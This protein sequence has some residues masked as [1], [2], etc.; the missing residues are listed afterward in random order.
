MIIKQYMTKVGKEVV[1]VEGAEVVVEAAKTAQ[2]TGI[3]IKITKK[4]K[5]L[6]LVPNPKR[7]H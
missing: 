7:A 2:V 1:V 6:R 3:T 5:R 4:P